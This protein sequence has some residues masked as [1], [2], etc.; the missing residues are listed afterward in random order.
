MQVE[1]QTIAVDKAGFAALLPL[2]V[3]AIERLDAAAKCPR[4]F[5]IGGRRVWRVADLRRWAELGFPCRQEFERLAGA[6]ARSAE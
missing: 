2:S 1:P 4:G 3:R 6:A 5:T